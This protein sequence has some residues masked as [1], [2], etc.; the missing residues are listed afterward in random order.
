MNATDAVWITELGEDVMA[1]T[2]ARADAAAPLAHLRLAVKDNIDVAHVP[3]TA[4]CPAFAYTP[5]RSAP[6]VERLVEAGAVVVG[7]TNLDQFATGLTG[8]RSPYGVGRSVLDPTLISGGSSSGSAVAV[9]AGMADVALGTDTAGSGR[10]PA[11]C[12][13]IVGYKPT[14]GLLPIRGIV[15]ACRSIDCP[16]VFTRTVA[17]ARAV[18]DVLEPGAHPPALDVMRSRLRVGVP[19]DASLAAVH[20]AARAAF[21]ASVAALDAEIVP[22]DLAPM[23]AAGDLLYGGAWL[24]E[25]YHSVGAFIEAHRAEV[26]DVVAGIILAARS[27]S[28]TDAFTDRYRLQEL[29]E[30]A[31]V[32]WDGIDVLLTPTVPDVPTVDE[33][34]ADP[35]GT[36][37]ALGRFTTFT[38]LLGYAVTAVPGRQRSD[39][40]PAGLSVVG[41]GGDDHLTLDVA[42]LVAGEVV[43]PATTGHGAV[44]L[45]VVG[46]HLAGEPLN[47][48]LS[49]R[50]GVLRVRTSTAP[51]YRLHALPTVPPK[52][53]LVKVPGAGA[54]IEVEVWSLPVAEFGAFVA[55]V[56][57]PLAIGK[58]ELDDGREVAGFVCEPAPLADAP[59]ITSYGGWRAYRASRS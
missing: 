25:R 1:T 22:L 59:D 33:V 43:P 55:G 24:A 17:E 40:V 14:P 18:L 39:G 10:V 48:E 21:A 6:V 53:G 42:S 29:A 4:G 51:V 15:P 57:A 35:I 8:S 45:A 31:A 28:A 36:N 3:T 23:F 12:N 54:A 37:I 52:P 13:G 26:N 41:R 16:S 19:D 38:N 47:H 11:A 27:L 50:G 44:D 20:P 7:K 46:A 9:A 5:T 56:P 32:R 49:G 2:A 58:V 30:A 34:A